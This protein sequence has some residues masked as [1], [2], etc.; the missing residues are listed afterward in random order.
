MQIVEA[1]ALDRQMGYNGNRRMQIAD[2][3][4][5]Y[6]IRRPLPGCGGATVNVLI[7]RRALTA[8]LKA[9]LRSLLANLSFLIEAAREWGRR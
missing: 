6:I 9:Y 4:M 7:V 3:Q 8:H 2:R 1:L 5:G